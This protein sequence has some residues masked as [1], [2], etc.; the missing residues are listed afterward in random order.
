M[1]RPVPRGCRLHSASFPLPPLRS[2]CTV[3]SNSQ[4][5]CRTCYFHQPFRTPCPSV[6]TAADPLSGV[7][8][9]LCTTQ[10]LPGA[11]FLQ[12][13]V[14]R[15][16]P[17]STSVHVRACISVCVCS[18]HSHV[19]G[20]LGATRSRVLRVGPEHFYLGWGSIPP[21]GLLG[22][23]AGFWE[24]CGRGPGSSSPCTHTHAFSL[25]SAGL[26]RPSHA[27]T[28]PAPTLSLPQG[29][30]P[31]WVGQGLGQGTLGRH[32]Q[33][34]L[35]PTPAASPAP[36]I[37]VTAIHSLP[38]F[39]PKW[40]LMHFLG[41]QLVCL[42]SDCPLWRMSCCHLVCPFSALPTPQ[43]ASSPLLIFFQSFRK[44]SPPE[45]PRNREAPIK[46]WLKLPE[47]F[48]V[49]PFHGKGCSKGDMVLG[50][51]PEQQ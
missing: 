34:T 14:I 6:P 12:F 47:M 1:R 45:Q 20:D 48:R 32:T 28:G 41:E 50:Q 35:S 19:G 46:E 43:C 15:F 9:L 18:S 11:G 30:L 38:L 33:P 23:V 31:F 25:F 17:Y 10:H 42:Q 5:S 40:G 51:G 4:P 13:R 36:V 7:A 24:P 27:R 8:S 39:C 21:A 26:C 37:M 16:S 29:T 49:V 44:S 2:S 3:S 22:L